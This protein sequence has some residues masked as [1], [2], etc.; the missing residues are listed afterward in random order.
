MDFNV[1]FNDLNKRMDALEQRLD[2]RLTKVLDAAQKEADERVAQQMI[3][4][5]KG[6]DCYATD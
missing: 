1:H 5:A 4:L 6:G 3:K 2:A